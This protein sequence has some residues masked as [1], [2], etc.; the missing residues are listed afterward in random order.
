MPTK[1]FPNHLT[2]VTGL[3]PGEFSA[4][5]ADAAAV[6]FAICQLRAF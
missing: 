3:Y 2:I 1:T 4:T 6:V 5:A